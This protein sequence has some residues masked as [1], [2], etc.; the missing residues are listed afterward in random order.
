MTSHPFV[1][2]PPICRLCGAPK[3][4]IAV[5][6]IA[7]ACWP[8]FVNAQP[9]APNSASGEHRIVAPESTDP[10]VAR[11]NADA[12]ANVEYRASKQLS[13]REQRAA[14]SEA[15]ARYKEE[16]A[17]ARINRKADRDA[18]NNALKATELEQPNPPRRS[19]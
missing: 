1:G 5:A 16:V 8:S 18:A 13:K 4:A 12:Q 6:S 9:E 2:L 19:H 10:F 3:A 7:F 14:V 17:N 15:N 11:R